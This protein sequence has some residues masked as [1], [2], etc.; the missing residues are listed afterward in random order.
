MLLTTPRLVLR[1][2]ELDDAPFM[3]GLLTDPDWLR[4]I[5]DRGVR[6][7]AG[8]RAYLAAGPI[9]MA[10]RE[11][12]GM[13]RVTLASSG[14]AI[15]VCGLVKREGLDDVDLG[16]AFLPAFRGQGYGLEA[17]SAVLA[18]ARS[19]LGLRR[20]VA[21]TSPENRDSIALLERIGFGFERSTVLAEGKPA[22]NLSAS[23]AAWPADGAKPPPHEPI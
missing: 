4:F 19:A 3:L 11:G 1:E 16:F 18:H 14:E 8:A 10:L 23:V 2:L 13:L 15:G 9:A 21:I 17:A 6:D 5:G 22:V 12:F 7:V 20:I